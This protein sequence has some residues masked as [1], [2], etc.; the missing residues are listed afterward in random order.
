M[1]MYVY[2]SQ[3]NQP[4]NLSNNQ[5]SL[6][7]SY[8]VRE[9]LGGQPKHWWD[10]DLLGSRAYFNA[11]SSPSHLL[12]E[13]LAQSDAGLYKC[14]VDF[15]RAPTRNTRVNLTVVVPPRNVVMIEES[16]SEVRSY[17]GPVTEG[18]DLHISCEALGGQPPPSLIWLLNDQVIDEVTEG[19]EGDI[20]R[21]D[22]TIRG[23]TRS[24]LRAHLTCRASNNK[25]SPP[26]TAMAT[27]DMNLRPL[28]VNI[29]HPREPL[30]AGRT[31][32]VLCSSKGSR[33]PAVLTWWRGSVR[34]P[35]ASDTTSHGGNVSSSMVRFTPNASDD[36]RLLSC[37]AENRNVPTAVI[38]DSWKLSV[39]YTPTAEAVLG[40]SL[41]PQNIREGDDV[42]F[43]CRV[44]ANPKAY[45]VLWKHNGVVVRQERENGV[46]LTNRSL[47]VQEVTRAHA[48]KY[49]CQASNVEGD[50]TSPPIVLSV[51]YAPV[52][53]SGQVDTYGVSKL[54]NAHVSCQVDAV[55]QVTR[56]YW[57]FNNTAES[58][59]VPQEQFTVGLGGRS[60][61]I[62]T[63]MSDLDYGTLLCSAE[64]MVGR[65]AEPCVFQI[66]PATQPEGPTNC[67][68]FNVSA[69]SLSV[70][71]APGFDG[72]LN[73]TFAMEVYG[74]NPHTLKANV[75]S[76]FPRFLVTGLDNDSEFQ[77]IVY[78]GNAK[79]RSGITRLVALTQKLPVKQLETRLG[80]GQ[81]GGGANQDALNVEVTPLL[82][83]VAGIVLVLVVIVVVIIVILKVQCGAS[84]RRQQ[85]QQREAGKNSDKQQ[86]PQQT[87][88]QQ[89]KRQ[90]Q[91]QQQ[92]Q[93]Q[94]QQ[95]RVGSLSERHEHHQLH[96]HPDDQSPDVVA[97]SG[98]TARTQ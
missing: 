58:L 60:V 39:Y 79:G 19:Q 71:C 27:I 16:G 9:L 66:I 5:L 83:V 62:Y 57:R 30:S 44:T 84:A 37:R 8:D 47:V 92:Q 32:E 38:E 80:G 45:K 21:N 91:Q 67:T 33:P 74:T 18:A 72:G 41:N 17:I 6:L 35:A 59:E 82:G 96:L 61:V 50:A 86:Q 48:G 76:K 90:Q 2:K 64:N 65:Q 14:R 28:D 68:L 81:S 49:T 40:A 10:A 88:Q 23:V 70:S 95:Q 12:L 1:C 36:G 97:C 69:S 4:L 87:Q 89:Q 25:V 20:T 34:L 73:Q 93:Q 98:G 26:L 24:M 29:H 63:P 52:C 7:H 22:L 85:A 55:P 78:A 53:R 13:G 3:L 51:Q 43:E 15:Q 77:L 11:G 46:L 75:T 31:Y 56:F 42:Y 54:E 94:K